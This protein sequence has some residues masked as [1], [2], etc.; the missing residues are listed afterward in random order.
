MPPSGKLPMGSLFA[1]GTVKRNDMRPFA[2]GGDQSP[3]DRVANDVIPFFR[4]IRIVANA[5]VEIARLERDSA[6]C[7][8]VALKIRNHSRHALVRR[9]MGEHVNVIRHD[10]EQ[11]EK[12]HATR[13]TIPCRLENL[14]RPVNQFRSAAKCRANCHEVER[15]R[16]GN[17]RNMPKL[18][19]NRIGIH[20][21]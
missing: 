5:R 21:Q 12:P 16:H 15:I 11:R 4:E 3:C 10:Q 8:K 2:W 9:K 18:F 1:G 6:E 7:R 13:L 20:M 17:W 19:A 14:G